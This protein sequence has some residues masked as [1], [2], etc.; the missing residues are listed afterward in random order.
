M[1]LIFYWLGQACTDGIHIS[2][3]PMSFLSKINIKSFHRKFWERQFI[4]LTQ[5][6]CANRILEMENVS[7]NLIYYQ[8]P[9]S[10][11]LVEKLIVAQPI[12]SPPFMETEGSVLY[13][14]EPAIDPH[15]YSDTFKPI[16]QTLFLQ[17]T[18]H[19][20][21]HTFM[22]LSSHFLSDLQTKKRVAIYQR[23][24]I[25]RSYSSLP[26]YFLILSIVRKIRFPRSCSREER[27]Y[28]GS[29]DTGV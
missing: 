12:N 11:V 6:R 21:L 1:T 25:Q 5:R 20:Y 26:V 29:G 16:F 2:F 22:S 17:H 18:F 10:R 7:C 9:Y 15:S 24:L 8:I 27:C 28:A 3:H 4:L 19:N 13:S 23:H 14:Q